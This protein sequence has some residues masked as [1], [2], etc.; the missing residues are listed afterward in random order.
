M[1]DIFDYLAWR[2]DLS[3]EH[4]SYNPVDGVI[5]ARVSYL[6][7]ESIMKPG[8]P[9]VITIS[10]ASKAMLS[11][12]DIKETALMPDDIRLMEELIKRP[13]FR[14]MEISNFANELDIDT[15]TQFSAVTIKI[16]RKSHYISF[17]GTDNTLVGWKED[18]NMSFICPVPAQ[19]LAVKYIRHT[20]TAL[21]GRFIV[22]GHSKGGNLAVYAAAFCDKKIQNRIDAVYNYDGPGF[23]NKVLLT[24]GY[25]NICEKISTFVPQSS[26]VGMLLG[27]EEKYIIVHSSN[28]T[29]IWQH[30]VY[31]WEVLATGFVCMESVDNSS[32]F[33]DCTLK[34]WVED[35]NYDQRESFIDT[36]YGIMAETNAVTLRELNDNWF[37]SARS[38]L[39][40]ITSLDEP[41]R[42]VV[43]QA[44]SLLV[45]SAKDSA[46]TML[47]NR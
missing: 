13:R 12:P 4:S 11:L 18:F 22:G 26:I 43:S 36:V 2:G 20:A 44:L 10:E 23:D 27:H 8:Y 7:F 35:L 33:I 34:N 3:M 21:P 47:Q 6:P 14:D 37:D 17:R 32:R 39:K 24:R 41:T 15:Q 19:E 5:L 30:D 25:R 1:S 9:D 29:G 16:N 40:S 38:V 31:S 42:K 46:I 45:K 28:F